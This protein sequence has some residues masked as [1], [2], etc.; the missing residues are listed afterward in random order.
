[1]ATT[2][3]DPS[4]ATLSVTEHEHCLHVELVRPEK[5]N[6]I[7]AA[8]AAELHGVCERLEASPKTLVISG[9][10]GVFAAGADL[11]EMRQRR[12]PE[13]LA[14]INSFLFR[15]IHQLPMPVIA[16]VDG[17]ALGGG[18]ELAYAADFRIASVNARFGNP[19]VGLGIAAAAGGS[20]RLRELVGEPMAKHIL[21]AGRILDAQESLASGLVTEVVEPDELLRSAF[22]LVDQIANGAPTAVRLTKALMNMPESAHPVVDN[23]AQ[24]LLFESTEKFER[25]TAFLEKRNARNS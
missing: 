10:G 13:A 2:S 5:K 1:M 6:A 4:H 16:A 8:M 20:W 12:S 22:R 18:A 24:A 17:W 23:M 19:E 3:I 21:L 25:M 11:A 9:S 15:R 14:G 7:D